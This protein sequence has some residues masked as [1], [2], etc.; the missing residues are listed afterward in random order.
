[1]N[2]ERGENLGNPVGKLAKPIEDPIANIEKLIKNIKNPIENVE[3]LTGN[4]DELIDNTK[5]LIE[6]IKKPRVNVELILQNSPN[7]NTQEYL[8]EL[9]FLFNKQVPN[10]VHGATEV[11]TL[12]KSHRLIVS[13]EEAHFKEFKKYIREKD[14][15]IICL[16]A[17]E[18]KT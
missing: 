15:N 4:I 10:A 14:L 7:T 13:V 2:K 9:T 11:K 5:Q 16:L 18:K 17:V 3:E 8:N 6:S 1:M 12:D